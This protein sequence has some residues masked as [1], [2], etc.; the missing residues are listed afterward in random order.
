MK[1]EKEPALKNYYIIVWPNGGTIGVRAKD[2]TRVKELEA[3]V[4]DEVVAGLPDTSAFVMQGNL[5][6][7]G[8][9]VTSGIVSATGRDHLGI[10]A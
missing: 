9:T 2:Q 10:T 3:I 8:Q 5:F 7:V 6:G 1:G 4:R